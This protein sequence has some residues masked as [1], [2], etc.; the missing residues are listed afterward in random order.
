MPF[1]QYSSQGESLASATLSFRH[2]ARIGNLAEVQRLYKCHGSS[3]V[4]AKNKWTALHYACECGRL[5]VIQYLVE[6]CGSN[7]SSCGS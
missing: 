4:N 5:E 2:A 1:V 7:N 3:I 6:M